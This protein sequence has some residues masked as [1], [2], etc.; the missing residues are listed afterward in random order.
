MEGRTAT[1]AANFYAL[2]QVHVTVER[3]AEREEVTESLPEGTVKEE[4][5]FT[6]RKKRGWLLCDSWEV[7]LLQKGVSSY[8]S[9]ESAWCTTYIPF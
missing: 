6:E 7:L 3:Q 8:H 1:N 2:T 5:G 4:N 9:S